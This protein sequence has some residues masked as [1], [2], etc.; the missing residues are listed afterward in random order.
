[1][2]LRLECVEYASA[3]NMKERRLQISKLQSEIGAKNRELDALLLLENVQNV[4]PVENKEMAKMLD[5]DE[6]IFQ[7]DDKMNAILSQ[8]VEHGAEHQL[9]TAEDDETIAKKA[10]TT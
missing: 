9:T 3:M 10:K 8:A 4:S 5:T 7:D 1:M 6:D 2:F